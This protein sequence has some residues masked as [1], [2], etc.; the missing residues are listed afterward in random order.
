MKTDQLF[1][2]FSYRV[3]PSA[4]AAGRYANQTGPATTP[5]LVNLAID[6]EQE[7][8]ALEGDW[9]YMMELN[10]HAEKNWFACHRQQVYIRASIFPGI[11]I[12]LSD[13]NNDGLV[14]MIEGTIKDNDSIGSCSGLLVLD[15]NIHRNKPDDNKWNMSFYLYDNGHEDCEIAFRLPVYSSNNNNNVLN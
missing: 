9:Q 4:V 8:F 13:E 1:K 12:D 2:T 3:V 10:N 11:A 7:D 5:L 14:F 15:K 6:F